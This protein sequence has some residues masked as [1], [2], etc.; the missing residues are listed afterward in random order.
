MDI[1]DCGGMKDIEWKDSAGDETEDENYIGHWSK[2]EFV[3]AFGWQ[4][5][6]KY[7]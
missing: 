3:K 6:Y 2:A 5:Y 4:N 1:G 7:N